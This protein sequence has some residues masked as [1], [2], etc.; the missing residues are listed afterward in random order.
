MPSVI[1]EK[2]A[3][4][5]TSSLVANA[6]V[7]WEW[8]SP[9]RNAHALAVFNRA[10]QQGSDGAFSLALKIGDLFDQQGSLD[11]VLNVYETALGI[12]QRATQSNPDDADWQHRLF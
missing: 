4:R 11:R 6:D 8:L 3:S 1:S 10:R 9:A 5:H 12:A 7:N 2:L